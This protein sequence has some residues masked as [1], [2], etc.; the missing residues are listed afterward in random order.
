M[1]NLWTKKS[2][3]TEILEIAFFFVIIFQLLSQKVVGRITDYSFNFSYTMV[4]LENICCILFHHRMMMMM[5]NKV[6]YYLLSHFFFS[7]VEKRYSDF[8]ALHKTLSDRFPATVFPDLPHKILM[9]KD[10]TPQERRISFD[11]FMKFVAANPKV[12]ASSILLAFLG[13]HTQNTSVLN[14][15]S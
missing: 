3:W 13:K 10:S 12:V 15:S 4:C 8:E 14:L 2:K 1:R 7:Q 9:L 11:Q 6:L 5:M